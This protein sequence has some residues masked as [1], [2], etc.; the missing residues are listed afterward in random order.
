M[1]L[2]ILLVVGTGTVGA[3]ASSGSDSTASQLRGTTAS[4]AKG[5]PKV[6]GWGFGD[7]VAIAT[8]DGTDVWVANYGG[9]V[10]EVNASTGDLVKLITGS[11]YGST[12]PSPSPPTAPTCGW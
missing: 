7:P 12:A 6:L 8:D 10:T 5:S 11:S 9:S 3:S 2:V 4:T 1:L